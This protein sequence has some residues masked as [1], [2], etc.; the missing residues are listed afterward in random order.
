[1]AI[2]IWDLETHSQVSLKER[3]AH[4]LAADPSTDIHF[5]CYAVDDGEVQ[6]WKPGDPV[7]EAFANP[8]D[9]FFVADNW[10]FERAIHMHILVKRY[11][12]PPIPLENQDCAQRLALANAYPAEL[13]LRCE[14]LGLPYKKDPETRRAMLRLS[15]PQTAKKRKKPVDPAAH[16][17]DLELVWERCKNDV[18][19]TRA[20]YHS[21]HLRPLLPE[22]RQVLLAD[23][24]INAHGICANVPF[25]EAAQKFAIQERNAINTRLNELT[26]GVITSVNQVGKIVEAV[27]AHG[28]EMTSLSK[29]SVAATLAHQPAGFVK[30]LLELR[31]RGAFASAT[32]FKRLLAFSDPQDHRIR[33]SL[34]IYGGAT[35][36]WSSLGAQL[37]NLP[38][39]D[40]KLPSSLVDALIAG[41]RATLAKWGNPLKAVIGIAR[42]A[43]CAASKHILIAVDFGAIE[44]RITAWLALEMWKLANF[45]AFDRTG[46]KDLD[47]Y[48]VVAHRTLHK[49]GPVSEI[50]AAERQ[51]GKCAEL[52]CGFGG[53]VGAWRRIAHDADD[54]SDEEVKA[55]IAQWR[56]QHPAIRALW[57][58][59]A[60][61]ARV[62]IKTGAPILV[63]PTPR[64][65]L[66]VTFDGHTMSITLPSGRAIHYPGAHLTPNTKFEGADPDIEFFDNARGQWKP[67]RAWFGTLVEN[68]VQA[69]A[70]DLLAA[71]IVRSVVFHCHDEM[72]VE[73]PESTISEAEVLK[74]LLE[75][76]AWAEGL[77][78]GGKAHSGPIY[79]EAPATAEP[80]AM[81][82]EQEIVEQAV[83]AFVAAT[84]PNPAIARAADAD[85]LASLNDAIAPLTDL[86]TLPMDANG[87]VSCPFHDDPVP[88]CKI[89][90]DHFHCFGCGERGDRVDWLMR[91]E[92]MTKAEALAAIEDWSGSGPIL[93]DQRF[94]VAARV[95]L[96]RDIWNAAG[97]IAGTLGARYL[98]ETR[99]IDLGKLP[100]T[101]HQALRFHPKCVFGKRMLHPCLVVLMRDPVTDAPTGIHRIGLGVESG[102]VV[103]LD[104][105]ALGRMGVVKLWP[106]NGND[107]LVVGEGI[108]TVLAAATCISYR[109]APL[110]PAWS[111][112]A[113]DGLGGLPVLPNVARLILLVDNDE[114]G[115]GQKAAAHCRQVWTAAGRTVAA[116]VP[117]HVG[118]D[119]NDVVLGRK[120]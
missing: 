95:A 108:E 77:P 71:A 57:R 80:P 99:G 101:I 42:A 109:D 48:C 61:A 20:A 83:D 104:R 55:I 111:A 52:A 93:T 1:M 59:L 112:I 107:L 116:L 11:G 62:A 67:V 66:T 113:R 2:V 6:T 114:N 45:A 16:A 53:S 47:L 65:P 7:P 27:N 115:E 40:A 79:L 56:E 3:G 5:F 117:K 33:G 82:S 49:T 17:R 76:P 105:M 70:R 102:A 24:R 22:E 98:A 97:P 4:V 72:V 78:L 110:T 35:G 14:A 63:A 37:H 96:A 18:R 58:E 39:N 100:P 84:P 36:R 81:E 85:Y 34:R 23:A 64:P 13:G 21:P 103:K 50:V 91:A 9:Y 106:A 12:F 29:R 75:P 15:R 92:N 28:H 89:Y 41:D 73:V 25:L 94:D 69:V 54:R 38:R 87:H 44:S 10:E 74:L 68:V 26:A 118:W 30:D 32:K 19:A 31:Q 8:L 43:L 60:Q 51:L 46:D 86:V 120:A 88:S 90:A 119:F